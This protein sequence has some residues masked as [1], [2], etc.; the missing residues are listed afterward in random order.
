M[1]WDLLARYRAVRRFPG[2]SPQKVTLR[3]VSKWL[4]QF[5]REDHGALLKLL[6]RVRY[7]SEQETRDALMQSNRSLLAR[8]EEAGI[9]A[10]HVIYMQI[11]EAGSSSPVMLNM[12]RDA[13][14]LEGRGCKFC[15]SKDILGFQRLM[16][17]LEEG[18][19]VYVDDF[20]GTGDQ[21]CGSRRYLAEYIVG[22]FSEFF[23]LP[24]ICEE[25]ESQVAAQ[26]VE[27]VYSH[28]DRACDRPLHDAGQVLPPALKERLVTLCS[29]VIGRPNSGLG[30]HR[31][32]AMVVFYRNAV[33]QVPAVLRGNKLQDRYVGVLPR[34]TD[35]PCQ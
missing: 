23:L 34:T 25:A 20:A 9:P 7:F 24:C 8:L 35:L 17:K 12:L 1:L 32:A 19:I 6:L 4:G 11:D 18:A 14:R 2:Y 15:D 26:G 31:L 13:A 28:L 16:N 33:N 30:Y 27:P 3:T 29:E 5:P 21:F 22:S 10:D